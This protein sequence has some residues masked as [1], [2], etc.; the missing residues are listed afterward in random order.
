[1]RSVEAVGGSELSSLSLDSSTQ[2]DSQ[3][4]SVRRLV[5]RRESFLFVR[6]PRPRGRAGG[7]ARAQAARAADRPGPA[8]ARPERSYDYA[9][10]GPHTGPHTSRACR[11]SASPPH[12][13]VPGT[14]IQRLTLFGLTF[15]DRADEPDK[16]FVHYRHQRSG[17]AVAARRPAGEERSNRKRGARARGA[18]G[19][20]GEG[21][22]RDSGT[23]NP[24][25][26]YR[27][28]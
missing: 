3:G 18:E 12:A 13:T 9:F 6:R 4:S 25:P 14:G 5:R 23:L 21:E 15:G 2:L 7:R 19:R 28:T 16:R 20:R 10:T 27:K 24:K 11:V 8:P 1:L 26:A 17:R 22:G